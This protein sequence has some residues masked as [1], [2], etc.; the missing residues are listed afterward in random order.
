[1]KKV[2][3]FGFGK[4]GK[5][6]LEKLLEAN[7]EICCVMT[8]KEE[9]EESVDT[10]C[11]KQNINYFYSDLRTD[12]KTKQ[13]IRKF[14]IKEKT[15]YLI[16]VNYRY[17]IDREIFELVKIPFNIHGSLLPKYRGRTPHIWSI[18]NGEKKSGVTCHL[19]EST[20]D[21]GDIILQ[22]EIDIK[23]DF[24][25]NDL[26]IE[27]QKIYPEILIKAL[28]KLELKEPLKKQDE[29]SATYYGKRIPEMGYIN[30]YL[31]FEEINNF[32]RAQAFP[33]PGA[34]FYL[35]NGKKI[36]ID[37]VEKV[38]NY[39]LDIEIGKIVK[40][41]NEFFIRCKDSILKLI[42]YRY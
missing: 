25:G 39:N 6:C 5:K 33:Y 31:T 7:F 1:M 17:I 14:L 32:I 18:I 40:I 20:V 36:I 34:Y 2:I 42:K 8:H 3:F 30:F 37:K 23:D 22:Y 21:T 19:I 12:L 9:L 28:K 38:I 11:K 13:K 24:T 29:M 16:S 4:L 10:F 26:L 15:E 27:M 41:E 35:T